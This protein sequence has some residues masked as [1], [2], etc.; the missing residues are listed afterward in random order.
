[1]TPRTLHL[2][3]VVLLPLVAV[4][5]AAGPSQTEAVHRRSAY[6]QSTGVNCRS[7]VF[8]HGATV[9]LEYAFY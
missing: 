1:M 6:V 4:S 7:G 2:A 5:Q 3:V 8:Y 9:G